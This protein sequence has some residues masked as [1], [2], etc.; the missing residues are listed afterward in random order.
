MSLQRE[1]DNIQRELE[2][3][4]MDLGEAYHVKA[5]LEMKK[6]ES[7]TLKSQLDDEEQNRFVICKFQTK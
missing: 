4:Q 5:E 3:T 1:K 6:E 7:H 2:R